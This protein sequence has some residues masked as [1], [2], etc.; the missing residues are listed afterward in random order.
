LHLEAYKN[1]TEKFDVWKRVANVSLRRYLAEIQKNSL[2][3]EGAKEVIK[4]L[5]R[6]E[7][8]ECHRT[9]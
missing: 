4:Y 2:T 7:N 3:G 6:D 9:K 5:I 8:E 1:I